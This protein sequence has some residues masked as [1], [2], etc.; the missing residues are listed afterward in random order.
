MT[1]V[2][3]EKMLT[4]VL[5]GNG[6]NR[7]NLMQISKLDTASHHY[8]VHII[9]IGTLLISVDSDYTTKVSAFILKPKLPH[10]YGNFFQ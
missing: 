1:R 8:L 2:N 10:K 6:G 4:L 7:N 3:W 5:A 9:F